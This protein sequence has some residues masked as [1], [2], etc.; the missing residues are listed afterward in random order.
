MFSDDDDS[1]LLSEDL[2]G[3]ISSHSCEVLPFQITTRSSSS[4]ECGAGSGIFGV[5]S[6]RGRL[7]S[8]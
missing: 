3:S 5:C 7:S 6:G 2:S 4:N 1:R 8:A